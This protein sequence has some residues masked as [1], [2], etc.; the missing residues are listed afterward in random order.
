MVHPRHVERVSFG[1][2]LEP[3]GDVVLHGAGQDPGVGDRY[4][5]DPFRQYWR[6]VGA[7]RPLLYMSYMPLKADMPAFVDGL[8]RALDEYL[9]HRLVPQI[10]LYLNGTADR[11]PGRAYD[12]AVAEGLLDPQIEAFCAGMRRLGRP[13]YL[14]IG[15]EFNGG[16]NGYQPE[17]FKI[18]WV[19]I[20]TAL[21]DHGLDDVA[22]VWCYCPLPSAGEEPGRI[23]RDYRPYYPGDEWVDWW[24]IDLFDP[25][26]FTLDNTHWFM[27]DAS[28]AGFPVMIGESTPRWVG[29]VGAGSEAWEAW[30]APYFRFIRDE[31]TVKATGYI[32][33]D[34]EAYPEF[35][36]WGDA[37]LQGAP[38]ILDRY[39]AELADPLFLHAS[40][41]GGTAGG[42]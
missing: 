41:Q 13:A 32:N 10:G 30:Y 24:S 25:G 40:P 36:G 15:F 37:R 29:G 19:R 14:R 16:W 38:A 35:R 33:W 27:V 11:T 8:R 26:M 5:L 31:P 3:R 4:D 21:R 42:R 9:P 6:A 7:S 34:W 20:V 23:D 2:R 22:A 28:A 1:R 17:S 39:R 12:D 18:A